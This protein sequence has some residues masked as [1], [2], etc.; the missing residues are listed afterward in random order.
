[1]KYKFQSFP[2]AVMT[3]PLS[4]GR[5][6]RNAFDR[7]VPGSPA[8]AILGET[9]TRTDREFPTRFTPRQTPFSFIF[10][11]DGIRLNGMDNQYVDYFV[12]Y[13]MMISHVISH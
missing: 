13:C 10:V 2:P 7:L 8:T 4:D 6:A 1:M 12:A 9:A 11:R 3:L 5:N